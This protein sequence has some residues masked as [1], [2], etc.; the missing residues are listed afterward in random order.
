MEDDG[1]PQVHEYVEDGLPVIEEIQLQSNEQKREE[2]NY[3][4][5]QSQSLETI[6]KQ[7]SDNVSPTKSDP[8]SPQLMI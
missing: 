7:F 3:I 8:F 4:E 1:M 5:D 6:E 2:D